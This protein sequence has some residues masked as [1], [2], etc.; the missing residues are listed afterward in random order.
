MNGAQAVLESLKKEGVDVVFGYPGGAV[1]TLY[2]AVYQ[3]NFPHVLTRHEQGAVH[4][5]DGYARATGKVGVVFATSG[6]GAGNL[7]TGIATANIDSI[8][9]VCI[10]GQVAN[11]YIGKDSFQEADIVGITTP[12]TKHNYLVKDVHDLPRVLKE[13]FF[14][15][16]TGRPGPV[17]IDVAKDVFDTK[18]DYKY[19]QDVTLK[20]YTGDYPTDEQRIDEVVKLLDAAEQPLIFVGGGV[21][22]SDTSELVRKL[23]S[24]LG[25]P[26]VS[27][28]M[29]LGCLAAGTEGYLGFAGM[30]GAYASNMAIQQCDLL[31]CLGMRFSDR[32]TGKVAEFAP[33]AKIVHFEIDAAEVNKNVPADLCV[34]GDLRASLPLLLQKLEA[35]PTDYREQFQSW[36]RHVT[37]LADAHPFTYEPATGA[38]DVIRPEALIAKISELASDD[39]IAVTDVGQHQM[40]AAQ[41]YE[42]KRPR[43][44]LTS[45]GL[46]T[47]GFGLPAALGA[48]V[49]KPDQ[50]VILFTGDGSIMMNCQEFAT[51]ADNDTDVKVI[52]VHNFILGMVGQWQRLFYNHHYAQSELKGKT[53]FVKLAEAMG[54]KGYRL[55]KAGELDTL[56]PDILKEKG[57]TLIDVYVPEEEDVLP[58]VPGG[59]RLDQ[60]VLGKGAKK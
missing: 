39:T 42:A 56:L 22:L 40:W 15:A 45:G 41:F 6:P 54:C 29:G 13:A 3:M 1:L 43:H 27:T 5:A 52:V 30:H 24:G 18:F 50:P 46:G 28:L 9:L 4:A 47:M 49:G 55:T 23:Q 53:D 19:P 38:D 44:F 58:M 32:V 25:A 21:T 37:A 16:R 31:L 34:P 2:D 36:L 11:P 7:I 26:A 10:T 35:S 48:K 60:M 51:L 20:G 17:V 12:I 57:T 59:K 14:I 8:P 33:H